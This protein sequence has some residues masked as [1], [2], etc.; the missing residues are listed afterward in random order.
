[1]TSSI[2]SPSQ[3]SDQ[4]R[5]LE[6]ATALCAK[7]RQAWSNGEL[8]EALGYFLKALQILERVLG[9]FHVLTAKTY[10]WI[11]FIRKH[12]SN[13]PLALRAFVKASRIRILLL[14]PKHE[15]TQEALAAVSWSL[16]AQGKSPQEIGKFIT[17]LS[18]SLKHES[19]GDSALRKHDYGEA[20]SHY[21]WSMRILD[22]PDHAA[23]LGKLAFAYR[24]A[25]RS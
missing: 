3:P 19:M 22:D 23:V 2:S 16:H 21:E 20:I 15:A 14:R 24:G 13:Y 11:G 12:Q 1:M 8:E 7:G 4:E 9:M 25:G 17:S 18:E 5:K 6:Q 10:Y